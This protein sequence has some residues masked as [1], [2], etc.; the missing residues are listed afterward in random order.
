[1]LEIQGDIF[2]FGG[3]DEN[4]YTST[5]L[6]FSCSSGIG[7]WSTLNQGLKVARGLTIAVP[8]PDYFCLDEG[9][10][11]TPSGSGGTTTSLSITKCSGNQDWIGDGFC[12]DNNNNVGCNF[13]GGDCCGSNVYTDHCT[14]CLCLT[15]TATTTATTTTTT[16]VSCGNHYATNCAGCPQGNGAGWCNGDCNWIN[17]QCVPVQGLLNRWMSQL[18]WEIPLGD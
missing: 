10:G 15:T 9:E 7:S 3:S 12:N 2:L 16:S 11:T 6:Q 18:N 1:M 17:D 4:A 8:V 13:D 14:E 5:I